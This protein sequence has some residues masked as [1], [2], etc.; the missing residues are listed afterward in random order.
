VKSAALLISVVALLAGAAPAHAGKDEIVITG[1]VVVE[2]GQTLDDVIVVNGS[3]RVL[4]RVTGDLIAVS[5]PVRLNGPVE[6][7]V[8]MVA[9]RIVIGPGGRIDGDLTYGDEKPVITVPGAVRGDTNKFDW[10]DVSEP[11]TAFAAR[12][13]LWLAM[14][15]SSLLLGLALLWLA[16]RALEAAREIARTR[17]GATIGMGLGVFFG[18]PVVAVLL[19]ITLV[20]IP[21]AIAVL[22]ALLPVYAIGYT[23]TAWLLGRALVKPPRGRVPA[24]L[25]GWAILRVIAL[26]P[27]VGGLAWFG[28]TVFGLGALAIAVWRSRRGPVTGTPPAPLAA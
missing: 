27:W 21:L 6:G 10:S 14:T 28:A 4:G 25:A 3:V 23:T 7:D 5:A 26:I 17:T 13:A 1:D 9:D 12:L 20:G 18:L 24:F 2:R 11:F 8:V 19:F 22:L 16:P 15:V